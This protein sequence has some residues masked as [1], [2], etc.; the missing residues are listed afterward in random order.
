MTHSRMLN[1]LIIAIVFLASSNLFGQYGNNSI[2]YKN[3]TNENINVYSKGVYPGAKSV[4]QKTLYPGQTE[5]VSTNLVGATTVFKFADDLS[6]PKQTRAGH[7]F[8]ELFRDQAAPLPPLNDRRPGRMDSTKVVNK[9]GEYVN[10]YRSGVYPGARPE[11]V[12]TLR[13]NEAFREPRLLGSTHS[14][15]LASGGRVVREERENYRG[16]YVALI[17]VHTAPEPQP[18][19]PGGATQSTRYINRT[20]MPVTVATVTGNP[21]T[22]TPRYVRTLQPNESHVVTTLA[23][24]TGGARTQFRLANG[25]RPKQSRNL[26]GDVELHTV[27]TETFPDRPLTRPI[28]PNWSQPTPV[29]LG[30]GFDFPNPAPP[31]MDMG[32]LGVNSPFPFGG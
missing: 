3:A 24:W 26:R 16:I 7:G 21:M 28:R 1:A 23:G 29:D 19:K 27:S 14:F 5:S 31:V 13:P 32:P 25:R 18:S 22:A 4:F 30:A 15:K 9:T 12:Q 2:V 8:Y 6:A 10:V 11:F 20:G 17:K